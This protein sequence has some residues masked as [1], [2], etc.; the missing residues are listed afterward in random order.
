MSLSC[1]VQSMNYFAILQAGE[2]LCIENSISQGGRELQFGLD[3]FYKCHHLKI[4][5]GSW[6]DGSVGKITDCTCR[7][8]R[9]DSQSH[10][11]PHNRL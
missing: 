5:S 3:I 1:Q 8:L 11:V 10:M 4:D 9:F 6:R 7:G 2:T